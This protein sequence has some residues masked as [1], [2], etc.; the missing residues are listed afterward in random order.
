MT[1]RC[2]FKLILFFI[3]C[4]I[5]I[6]DCSL[7]TAGEPYTEEY[8]YEAIPTKDKGKDLK[9]FIEIR[10]IHSDQQIICNLKRRSSEAQEIIKI[11]TSSDGKF[12]SATKDKIDNFGKYIHIAEIFRDEENVYVRQFSNGSLKTKEYS[13]LR[14]KPLAVDASLLLLMRFFPFDKNME[15]DVFMVDFSQSSISVRVVQAD[16]ENIVVPAG[17]FE[18]YRM[19]VSVIFFIFR[20]KITYWITK[21]KPHFLVKHIGKRSPFTTSYTTSLVSVKPEVK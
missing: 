12:H 3:L 15:W 4:I 14:G 18:C 21:K 17:E 19:E 13:I 16:I 2:C 7:S 20:A 11:E 10:L 9:E 5:F 6:I 1:I 8:A